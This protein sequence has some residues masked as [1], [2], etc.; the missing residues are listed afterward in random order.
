MNELRNREEH[1]EQRVQ[2]V[3]DW[4][5]VHRRTGRGRCIRPLHFFHYVQNWTIDLN[6]IVRNER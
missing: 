2:W 1:M 3:V 6:A 4:I 5:N